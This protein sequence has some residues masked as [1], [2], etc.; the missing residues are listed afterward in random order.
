MRIYLA[1]VLIV[2]CSN[3]HASDLSFEELQSLEQLRNLGL[4]DLLNI[5]VETASG[6]EESLIDAPASMV[7]ITAEQIAQR[8]YHNLVEV[9]QDV[10]GFDV[11][12]TQGPMYANSYQRGYRLPFMSRTLLM[13]NGIVDNLLWSD[14]GALSRQYPLANIKH[15]EILYGPASAV[16]GP[17]AFLGIINVITDDGSKLETG[18][19]AGE[20]NVLK[21]SFK[22]R[23]LDVSVKGKPLD[24]LSFS[25]AAKLFK[26]NE[27]DISGRW[28]FTSNEQYS[29]RDIWGGILDFEHEGQPL[30]H[31][32]DP[33]DDYGVL[34]DISYKGLKLGLINWRTKEGYGGY[35]ASD[36]TQSNLFWNKFNEQYY[37]QYQAD[38]SDKLQAKSFISH[39]SSRHYGYWGEAEPDFSDDIGKHSFISLTQWNSINYSWL[40]KQDFEYQ[41]K[42][43][44]LLLSGLKYQRKELTKAYDVPGYWESGVSSSAEAATGIGHSTDAS[45]TPPPPPYHDM[46]EYNLAHTY[47]IG[48]YAQAIVDIDNWRF[49]LG[50]RYDK[51]SVYG[52][53]FNPRLSAI[54]KYNSAW[55]FKWLYGHAFQEPAPL[56]LWGGWS[57]RQANEALKPERV[58]NIEMIILHQWEN[59]F[60]ELSIYKAHYTDVI[61]EEAENAGQRDI[62]GIEYR[63]QSSFENFLAA[64]DINLY[65]NYSYTRV[66]SSLYYDHQQSAWLIGEAEL[67]DIAPHKWNIGINVPLTKNWHT[68]IRGN[69]VS[70]REPYLRNPLRGKRIIDDYFTLNASLHY[71]YQPFTVTLKVL[72]A[73]NEDYYQP[74]AEAASAGDDFTQRSLGYQN[75][76]IPQPERSYWLNIGWRF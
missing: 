68:N 7:I 14:E 24:D 54:Y 26:S 6:T 63:L 70:E 55:T 2:F 32:Y 43:N 18:K 44:I 23:G 40:F 67:G 13:F 22:S 15:I 17:N 48:G 49:N 52:K 71:Q 57:G 41:L 56:Q 75:S 38:L 53:V 46:L 64:E 33:T 47:D 51:N 8:G 11:N 5:T 58:Q 62:Y 27:A 35:Y 12:I 28:G 65:F 74:G 36:R 29:N 50:L 16:Y 61:K 72:N 19:Y 1:I 9:L 10:P 3:L 59:I 66:K 34:A 30:G 69:F 4:A 37:L 25:I 60:H 42:D 73:L 45:Y 21:G 39:Q 76:L 20:I 31:Y